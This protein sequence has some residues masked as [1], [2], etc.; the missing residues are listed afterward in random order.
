MNIDKNIALAERIA[1]EVQKAGG[2]TYYV[3]GYV[4]DKLLGIQSKDIDIEIYGIEVDVLEKI[5]D[6]I[7]ERTEYGKSFGIYGIKGYTLD[8]AFPR[9]ERQIGKGH[10]DFKIEIDPFI[11]PKIATKRRD[12][13]INAFMEN[14]ISGKLLD[15]YGGIEALKNKRICHIDDLSF[16]EDSLRVFRGAQLAARLDFKICDETRKLCSKMDVSKLSKERV[17]EELKKALLCS[18][19]P[20]IFFEELQKMNMLDFW[21]PEI[22]AL[23]GLEQNPVYHPEGDVYTHTMIVLENASKYRDESSYPYGFMLSALAHDFGKTVCTEI[24]DGRIIS[25]GH[26]TVGLPIVKK[27]IE[28]LTND[29]KLKKYVLN[30]VEN[31][32][33]PNALAVQN[34]S[35]KT[36]NKLFNDVA[37]PNDI[38]YLALSDIKTGNIDE[39]SKN[40]KF[41]YDRL[42]IYEDLMSK[43]YITGKDLIDSGLDAD[44]SFSDILEYV[45]KL[46]LSGIDKE[47]ALKMTIAYAKKINNFISQK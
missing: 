29:R 4:R 17:E 43:P 6:S 46:R 19:K 31:H 3:G 45:N 23:I 14:V 21:F 10:R 41:L 24:K 5:L 40:E 28:R 26:E 16:A 2:E 47:S 12:F 11:N 35:I 34:S 18:N 9:K 37:S 32:M 13:T 7:G 44:K 8:I 39:K 38:I 36:T 25:Y 30:M 42:K 22:K 20:Q 15:F 27:F 1:T 33:R